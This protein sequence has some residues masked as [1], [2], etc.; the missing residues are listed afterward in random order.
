MAK[1]VIARLPAPA[2]E[3]VNEQDYE[4]LHALLTASARGRAFL[5][6]HARRARNGDTDMLLT[7]LKRVESLI[8][9]K[10]ATVVALPNV[11]PVET[12]RPALTVVA[13]P[14]EPVVFR[15]PEPPASASA[16]PEPTVVI[17]PEP[18]APLAAQPSPAPREATKPPEV[19]WFADPAPAAIAPSAPAAPAL[20][21]DSAPPAADAASLPPADPLAAFLSLTEE[22]RL[23]LFT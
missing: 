15:P 12:A 9:A 23:A 18:V 2:A 19:S 20:K 10:P 13:P 1:D 5:D 16:L 14:P 8:V 3:A 11:E 17:A 22:E 4:L 6:E 21:T 7:A